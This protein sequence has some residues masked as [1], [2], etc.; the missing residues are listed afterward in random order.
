MKISLLAALCAALPVL[1]ADTPNMSRQPLPRLERELSPKQIYRHYGPAV[2]LVMCFGADGNG[3]MGTGS[4]LDSTGRI[5]TNAHV[6][7]RKSTRKPFENIRVYFKPQ[8]V[9]GDPKEDLT[10]PREASVAAFDAALDLAILE[11]K[12]PPGKVTVMPLG[13]AEAVDMGES[14]IAI[15][16][17]EQG[18]LWTLTQGVVS[19]VVSNLGGVQGKNAF[20]TDA[21]IN[22]G[23]SGGPLISRRGAMIGVNTSMA[24]KAQDGLTITSVN[25]AVKSSVLKKWLASSG[26]RAEY[27]ELAPEAPEE[28]RPA[29]AAAAPP[30]AVK[31]PPPAV[32]PTPA[33]KPPPPAAK[34]P[35]PPAEPRILTPKKP[36]RIDDLI[37]REIGEM[38]DLEKEMK[39][40]IQ[41][42]AGG[43]P[44]PP[45]G[46]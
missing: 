20:Q 5:V 32:K 19:T 6:V 34:A 33:V 16:H 40:E 24:R 18:G 26:I 3:E 45:D 39:D 28:S 22:R 17:P 15:G 10:H 35:P 1:A 42:R 31:A 13:D 38:E 7:I 11:L 12:D 44:A 36:F 21:S 25:F 30:A 2:V 4:V 46:D 9:T 41:K 27:S 37:E 14:V 23:N 43:S 29:A 8:R